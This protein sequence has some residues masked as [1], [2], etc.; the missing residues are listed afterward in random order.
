MG[1]TQSQLVTAG[2]VAR[3]IAGGAKQVINHR[4]KNSPLRKIFY[5]S[6]VIGNA[7]Q[8]VDVPIRAKVHSYKRVAGAA[9]TQNSDSG[10][11][12]PLTVDQERATPSMAL[13]LG[14][15]AMTGNNNAEDQVMDNI[16]SLFNDLDEELFALID[17]NV[18][19]ARSIGSYGTAISEANIATVMAA[20]TEQDNVPDSIPSAFLSPTGW[21]DLAQIQSFQTAYGYNA[22]RLTSTD[23]VGDGT[24][25][26]GA[27]WAKSRGVYRPNPTQYDGVI[28]YP[29]AVY[30]AMRPMPNPDVGGVVCEDIV[31]PA[32][33][34]VCQLV[35]DYDQGTKQVV[36]TARLLYGLAIAN[37]AW[38]ARIKR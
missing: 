17:A 30:A 22:V 34:V 1:L 21:Y 9:Y 27:R 12:F 13:E 8:T 19:S 5:A 24:P 35:I 28:F 15:Q 7:G 33:G 2:Q 31:D 23:D 3:Y 37:A 4:Y 16:R 26:Y 10:S 32:S 18:A 25:Y 29:E 20:L 14:V 11:S 36:M 6:E 38:L